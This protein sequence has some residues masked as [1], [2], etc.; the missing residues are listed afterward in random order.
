MTVSTAGERGKTSPLQSGQWFPHPA[1]DPVARTSAPHRITRTLYPT[2]P[3]ANRTERFPP[4]FTWIVAAVA[5][6]SFYVR[7][8]CEKG[9]SRS[10]SIA[11][12]QNGYP[13]A[14]SF[15]RW[16]ARFTALIN[17][18]RRPPSSSSRMPSTVHPAGVVTASFSSAGWYPVS[19]H[20]CRTQRRLRCQQGGHIARQPNIDTGLRQCLDD[21]V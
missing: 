4:R 16:V 21:D 13:F 14:S 7:E 3:H 1:P 15:A 5:I 2:T 10:I 11:L 12:R 20:P 8:V 19:D 17:V 9:R 18:T 6:A